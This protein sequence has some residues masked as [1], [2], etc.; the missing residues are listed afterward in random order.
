MNDHSPLN[1]TCS[2]CSEANALLPEDD[3]ALCKPCF[4][5]S[6]RIFS[7]EMR[8]IELIRTIRAMDAELYDIKHPDSNAEK[9]HCGQMILLKAG[10]GFE[11]KICLRPDSLDWMMLLHDEETGFESG[12]RRLDALIGHVSLLI[13]SWGGGPFYLDIFFVDQVISTEAEV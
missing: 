13:E 11:V 3:P 1:R 6:E 2:I 4:E 7:L 9:D 10:A 12:D 8:R 5:K